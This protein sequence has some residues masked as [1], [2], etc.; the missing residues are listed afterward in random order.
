MVAAD[1]KRTDKQNEIKKTTSATTTTHV[2][3]LYFLFL[4]LGVSSLPA[5]PPPMQSTVVAT[6]AGNEVHL[7]S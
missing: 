6:L 2:D 1:G 3:M 4:S 7:V 5:L